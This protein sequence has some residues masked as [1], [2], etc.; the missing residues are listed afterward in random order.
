LEGPFCRK[1]AVS[2]D[3]LCLLAEE[4]NKAVLK[5][6]RINILKIKRFLKSLRWLLFLFFFLEEAS[7]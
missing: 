5:A 6:I 1:S 4:E 3:R 2:A 7:R